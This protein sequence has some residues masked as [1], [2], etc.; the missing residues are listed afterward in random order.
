MTCG[1][2]GFN[3]NKALKWWS[4]QEM[5]VLW[6]DN[7]YFIT[8][9]YQMNFE[10]VQR[11]IKIIKLDFFFFFTY[12]INLPWTLEIHSKYKWLYIVHCNTFDVWSLKTLVKNRI[13]FSDGKNLFSPINKQEPLNTV[14]F[15]QCQ[16]EKCLQTI[17]VDSPKYYLVQIVYPSIYN[18]TILCA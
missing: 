1:I 15:M 16:T 3:R 11:P 12:S 9:I 18:N 8:L 17:L 10:S 14:V 2:A 4:I 5:Q 13:S 7:I 6:L